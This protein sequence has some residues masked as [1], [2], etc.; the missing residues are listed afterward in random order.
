MTL[1][2]PG[3]VSDPDTQRALD[4]IRQAFP[5]GLE[6]LRGLKYGTA[7]LTFTASTNSATTAVTHGLGTTPTAVVAT[8][9]MAPGF[10]NIPNCNAYNFGATSFDLNGELTAAYTGSISVSWVAIG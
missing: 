1:P 10:G 7:A 8:S 5:I 2:D 9:L 6:Q 4:A 3:L